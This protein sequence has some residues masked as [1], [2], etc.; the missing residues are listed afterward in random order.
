MISIS[1][2]SS[3]SEH[4]TKFFLFGSPVKELLIIDG[5]LRLARLAGVPRFHAQETELCRAL[6]TTN[7]SLWVG[8]LGHSCVM[9]DGEQGRFRTHARTR[10]HTHTQKPYTRTHAAY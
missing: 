10:T 6:W 1:R 9:S 8:A 5:V 2:F 3:S 7:R 4:H